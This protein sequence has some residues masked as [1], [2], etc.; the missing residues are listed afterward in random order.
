MFTRFVGL[1][2]IGICAVVIGCGGESGGGGAGGDNT[3]GSG[4]GSSSGS[5][6]GSTSGSGS[7]SFECCLN[8]E[9]FTCPSQGAVDQCFND[10][11]PSACSPTPGSCGGSTTGGSTSSGGNTSTTTGGGGDDLGS[12]CQDNADCMYDACLFAPDTQFG[13]CSKTCMDFTDCPTFWSCEEVGN[14]SGLYCVQ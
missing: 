11:D 3:N 8:D 5:G 12:Q 14:A 1:V 2:G 6:N 10:F 13:Y 4:N 9:H 7:S